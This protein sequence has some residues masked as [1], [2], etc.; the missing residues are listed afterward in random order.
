V[1]YLGP[2]NLKEFFKYNRWTK[3][4]Q[5]N[6]KN[7]DFAHDTI[8]YRFRNIL[9][10]LNNY[11]E[12]AVTKNYEGKELRDMIQIRPF[13]YDTCM[14]KRFA[15][16]EVLMKKLTKEEQHELENLYSTY[17]PTDKSNKAVF[18]EAPFIIT[19]HFFYYYILDVF[20]SQPEK[21]QEYMSDGKRSIMDP[22]KLKKRKSIEDDIKGTKSYIFECLEIIKAFDKTFEQN[23][24]KDIVKLSLDTNSCDLSQLGGKTFHSIPEQNIYPNEKSNFVDYIRKEGGKGSKETASTM[25]INYL[26]DNSSVEFFSDL[27]FAFVVLKMANVKEVNF[28]VNK[29]PI[30]VSDVIEDDYNHIMETIRHCIKQLQVSNDKKEE[31]NTSLKKIKELVKTKRINIKPDFI[32]NM[33]TEYQTLANEG[34]DIFRQQNAVLI[35]K[36]D[37]N[38]RRLAGDKMWSYKKRLSRITRNFLECP[39]LVIRSFKSDIVLDYSFNQLKKKNNKNNN[40]DRYWRENG[41]YGVIRFL[42]KNRIT[43]GRSTQPEQ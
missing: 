41:E 43:K 33:P 26:V 18:E 4:K 35:I 13:S 39:T 31:Y 16:P 32:W 17:L 3:P 8:R 15:L 19:E 2:E 37:L 14:E 25:V 10:E 20:Y 34:N 38:Y 29:L 40:N 24:L 42:P 6:Y 21:I 22:Y 30:F 7:D 1:A 5:F 36:G 27:T 28:H 9:Y 23:T 11:Y 12:D